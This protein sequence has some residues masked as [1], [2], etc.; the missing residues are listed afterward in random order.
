MKVRGEGLKGF[1]RAYKIFIVVFAII[2]IAAIVIGTKGV[3]NEEMHIY[4]MP[5]GYKGWVQIVYNQKDNPQLP[6]E[7]DA[8][9]NNIPKDGVLKT[10]DPPTSGGMKFYYVDDQ[11]KRTEIGNDMIHGQNMAGKETKLSDGTTEERMTNS[12]FVGTE[13]EYQNRT[14][15]NPY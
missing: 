10:S 4:V 13:Q 15:K 14:V 2:V 1:V 6:K 12:F 3:F 11:G 8:K 5:A 9:L 7:G